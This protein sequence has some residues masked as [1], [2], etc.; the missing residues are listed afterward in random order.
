M[1]DAVLLELEIEVSIGEAALRP[2]LLDDGVA[3]L[4][5]EIWM[6]FAAPAARCSAVGS[7]AATFR[8]NWYWQQLRYTG[9]HR[10]HAGAA[11][12]APKDGLID[13]ITKEITAYFSCPSA[14][15]LMLT[16][17]EVAYIAGGILGRLADECNQGNQTPPANNRESLGTP[18]QGQSVDTR[19]CV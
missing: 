4:R 19:K 3:S 1:R 2:V 16:P 11:V 15:G 13:V 10:Q 6:P 17:H 9:H 12:E 5:H 7:P 14:S 18:L 8:K